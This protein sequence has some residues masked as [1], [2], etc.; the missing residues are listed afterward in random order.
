MV[1]FYPHLGEISGWGSLPAALSGRTMLKENQMTGKLTTIMSIAAL[2]L[3]FNGS[4]GLA[5]FPL[6]FTLSWGFMLWRAER[7]ILKNLK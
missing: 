5:I 7:W 4:P 6:I 2:V 3:I 1:G